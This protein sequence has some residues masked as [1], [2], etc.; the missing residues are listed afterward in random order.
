LEQ[1]FTSFNY[2]LTHDT[3][4]ECLRIRGGEE[5]YK[6]WLFP[7]EQG[8]LGCPRWIKD[9]D[10]ELEQ[11]EDQ[12]DT[13]E[14]A[15]TLGEEDVKPKTTTGEDQDHAVPTEVETGTM[16]NNDEVEKQ[17]EPGSP[18]SSTSTFENCDKVAADNDKGNDRRNRMPD[19]AMTDSDTD[20]TDGDSQ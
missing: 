6:R 11:Q 10:V 13:T 2:L 8:V 15:A 9:A 16:T 7:N 20:N 3:V 5:Q 14:D 18:K 17:T 1:Q 19:L 4:N 12:E